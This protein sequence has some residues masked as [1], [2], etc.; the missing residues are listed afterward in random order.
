L[1]KGRKTKFSH[2]DAFE[3][4]H[5]HRREKGK[6]HFLPFGKLRDP[7]TFSASSAFSTSSASSALVVEL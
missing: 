4:A 7:K 5:R 3:L 2:D 6:F 1:P